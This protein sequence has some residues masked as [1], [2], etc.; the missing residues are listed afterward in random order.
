MSAVSGKEIEFDGE[1]WEGKTQEAKA[2]YYEHVVLQK[3]SKRL[4]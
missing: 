1:L 2:A 4:K 3:K